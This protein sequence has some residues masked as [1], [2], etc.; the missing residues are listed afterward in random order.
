M[1]AGG[2][3]R[4]GPYPRKR[5]PS[6]VTSARPPSGHLTNLSIKDPQGPCVTGGGG[7]REGGGG[8]DKVVSEEPASPDSTEIGLC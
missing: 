7:E 4:V 2:G 6:V 5:L 1:P 3:G 8:H